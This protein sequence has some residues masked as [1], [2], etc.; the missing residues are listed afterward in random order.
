MTESEKTRIVALDG[1][2]SLCFATIICWHG[3]LPFSNRPR[4]IKADLTSEVVDLIVWLLRGLALKEFFL[5]AGLLTQ[6]SLLRRGQ[7]GYLRHRLWRLGFPSLVT[8]CFYNWLFHFEVGNLVGLTPIQ[9]ARVHLNHGLWYEVVSARHLWFIV[10]L[11]FLTFLAV[12]LSDLGERL[13]NTTLRRNLHRC[14]RAVM[15]DWRAILVL[16]LPTTVMIWV[17]TPV[18]P[19]RSLTHFA[20]L[21]FYP[22]ITMLGYHSVFFLVG[23]LLYSNPGTLSILARRW[24]PHLALA[25]LA[26]G[27]HYLVLFHGP[28]SAWMMWPVH[29]LDALSGWGTALGFLGLFYAKHKKDRPLWRY[30]AD[31]SYWCYLTHLFFQGE[32]QLALGGRGWP[33]WVQYL[34]VLAGTW[35]FVLTSYEFAVRYTV[36]GKILHGPRQRPGGS[37]LEAFSPQPRSPDSS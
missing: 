24:Q 36:I 17:H 7:R 28:R 32:L 13:L 34:A 18:L 4:G 37:R 30:L 20:A 21:P 22:L 27:L 2:R 19:A 26:K 9:L 6:A 23:W 14:F 16:T 33:L 11:L 29:G 8:A 12:V 35:A 5:I 25:L 31:S 10:D 15:E 3:L 1:L